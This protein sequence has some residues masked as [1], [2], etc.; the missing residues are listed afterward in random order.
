MVDPASAS[1][2]MAWATAGLPAPVTARLHAEV[3]KVLN[4]P[5]IR[6]KVDE[7]GI[8]VIGNSPAE[9]AALIKRGF[10]VYGKA[11]ALSGIKP[12]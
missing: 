4:A 12:E 5:D 3:V 1:T 11:F 8:A 10:E 9:F 2:V 7:M 6:A